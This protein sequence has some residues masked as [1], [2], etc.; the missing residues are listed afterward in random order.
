M[1]RS[2]SNARRVLGLDRIPDHLRVVARLLILWVDESEEG[3]A[4]SLS[5]ELR[6]PERTPVAAV[7]GAASRIASHDARSRSNSRHRLSRQ[8]VT[9]V[10]RESCISKP[11]DFYRAHCVPAQFFIPVG[12]SSAR[13]AAV[14]EL[15]ASLIAAHRY[16]LGRVNAVARSRMRADVASPAR[17]V[18]GS[19]RH[20][21]D[22]SRGQPRLARLPRVLLVLPWASP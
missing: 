15:S 3:R 19:N 16:E 13:L 14:C 20:R 21:V 1:L 2:S 11:F 5:A 4:R 6:A 12:Q 9:G 7:G 8:L 17:P 22:R 10:A 18:I